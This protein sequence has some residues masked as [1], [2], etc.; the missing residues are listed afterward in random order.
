MI[1]WKLTD[2]CSRYPFFGWTPIPGVH[3]VVSPIIV[4]VI[5]IFIPALMVWVG[6][7][8]F[9]TGE[10]GSMKIIRIVMG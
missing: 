4:I 9:P 5:N 8:A 3:W 7:Q 10:L 2:E 6:G 1:S